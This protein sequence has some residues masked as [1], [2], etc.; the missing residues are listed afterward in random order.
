V[1]ALDSVPTALSAAGARLPAELDGVDLTPYLL[2]EKKGVPHE[3]LFWRY[4]NKIALRSGKWKVVRNPDGGQSAAPL[5]LYDLSVNIS[6]E[7]DLAADRPEIRE[8][9]RMELERQNAQM[10]EPLWQSEGAGAIEN[11]P[12][13]LLK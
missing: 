4:G 10:S 13:D 12:L 8:R 5:E 9:L 3:T 2:S 6:E 7:N 11:W 1:I